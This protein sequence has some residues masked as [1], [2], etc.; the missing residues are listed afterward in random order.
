MS[1]IDTWKHDTTKLKKTQCIHIGIIILLANN[2]VLDHVLVTW[3]NIYDLP[4]C[5]PFSTLQSS[6][7]NCSLFVS[8]E[9]TGWWQY[10]PISDL[11]FYN[12]ATNDHVPYMKVSNICS[13]KFR[14]IWCYYKNFP[15]FLFSGS[16][17]VNIDKDNLKFKLKSLIVNSLPLFP[18][19]IS[20]VFSSHFIIANILRACFYWISQYN[21]TQT[22]T[23]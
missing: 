21:W 9:I 15:A 8:F 17:R 11:Y 4:Q 3:R 5:L 16:P 20:R 7:L 13:D 2:I 19:I 12:T 18:L 6:R 10:S 14:H 23:S 22:F 1:S